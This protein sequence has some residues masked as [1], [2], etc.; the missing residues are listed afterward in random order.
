MSVSVPL[1]DKIAYASANFGKGLL[2][3]S[4]E[5]LLLFFL[6]D[7]VGI[8]PLIAGPVLM[9]CLIWDGVTDPMMGYIIDRFKNRVPYYATYIQYGMPATVIL[10][11]LSFSIPPLEGTA[12][13]TFVL[14]VGL[15]YRTAYSIMDVS[16]NAL[17]SSLTQNSTERSALSGLRVTFSSLGGLAVSSVLYFALLGPTNISKAS[18]FM[19]MAISFAFVALVT[20]YVCV[21][22]VKPIEIRRHSTE[23]QHDQPSS[24][25]ATLR[26]IIQSRATVIVFLLTITVTFTLP[27]YT[28]SV[29][30]LAKYI[31]LA[32]EVA[33]IA[34][35]I[36]VGTQALSTPIW[37]W[38]AGKLSTKVAAQAAH[39]MLT[40]ILTLLFFIQLSVPVFL[41]FSAAIGLCIAGV[42][43]TSW[44]LLAD[45]VD[46]VE[47]LSGVRPEASIFGLFTCLN[48]VCIG[49]STGL[50][51][52]TY[53]L[54]GF[55]ANKP[56]SLEV[57]DSMEVV[58]LLVP[59]VG[60]I[61]A[62]AVLSG[63]PTDT[64]LPRN[65][66]K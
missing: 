42:F 28:K 63:Y 40:L 64:S 34:L 16:H 8:S 30:Y 49:L 23:K 35:A 3:N 6:T 32:E 51:G 59:S 22:A 2:W 33:A 47:R 10:F 66:V 20:T 31:L 41:F 54:I 26:A 17:L 56:Q 61:L 45:S 43:T 25:K 21:R 24:I 11:V 53:S 46:E 9:A 58:A 39:L 48:K 15:L 37:V 36:M 7:I 13:V 60:S 12:L 55:A 1:K 57:K 19:N 18:G 50:I 4:T 38:V 14:I 29:I 27:F 52:L 44:A 62:I 65:N 5:L